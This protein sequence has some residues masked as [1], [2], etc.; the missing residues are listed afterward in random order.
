MKKFQKMVTVYEFSNGFIVERDQK[1]NC[2]ELYISHREY[3][4]KTLMFGL[5]DEDET[6]AEEMMLSELESYMDIYKERFF[7]FEDMGK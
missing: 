3:G 4:I 2:I 7:D 6:V 5:C 1:E